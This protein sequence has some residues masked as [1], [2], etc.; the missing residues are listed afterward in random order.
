MLQSAAA[1]ALVVILNAS[2]NGCAVLVLQSSTIQHVPLP[3]MTFTMANELV[4]MTRRAV[5]SQGGNVLL[6]TSNQS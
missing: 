1:N 3:K 5:A 4:M 6:P 2:K